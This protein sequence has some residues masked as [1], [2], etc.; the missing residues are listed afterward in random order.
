MGQCASH[1]YKTESLP[2]QMED[3]AIQCSFADKR[4]H[5]TAGSYHRHHLQPVMEDVNFTP[6]IKK[7]RPIIKNITVDNLSDLQ[8]LA[9]VLGTLTHNRPLDVALEDAR[10][11]RELL[12]L[13][14]KIGLASLVPD[15]NL[16]SGSPS[17]TQQKLNQNIKSIQSIPHNRRSYDANIHRH[18]MS[19]HYHHNTVHA[20]QIITM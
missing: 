12:G 16:L 1:E 13:S 8:R 4:V 3:K 18:V 15:F 6:T 5:S 7:R 19:N 11:R 17:A 9:K 20:N 10:R 14:P 2:P